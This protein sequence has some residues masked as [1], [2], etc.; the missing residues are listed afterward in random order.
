MSYSGSQESTGAWGRA[1]AHNDTMDYITNFSRRGI[2][3]IHGDADD[4]V[5]VREGRD[6]YEAVSAHTDDIYYHEQPG[7]GHWW[8]GDASAGADCVDWP[9]LFDLMTERRLDPYEL[10]F[11]FKSPTPSTSATH[12]YV[13]LHAASSPYEDMSL[14][15]SAS[16][17]NATLST[18]NVLSLSLQGDALLEQGITSISVNGETLSVEEGEMRVG[19]DSQKDSDSYGPFNQVLERPFVLV[20]PDDGHEAYRRYA[21]YLLSNWSVTGNG[22]GA[23]L[24]LSE[25]T[26]AMRAQYNVIYI[27]IPQSDVP[28]TVT[29]DIEWSTTAIRIGDR[30]ESGLAAVFVQPSESGGLF[31]VM[32]ATEGKE[33]VLFRYQPFASRFSAPDFFTFGKS[34]ASYSGFFDAQW[35]YQSSLVQ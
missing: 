33:A 26:D 18:T 24:G 32:T 17:S 14:T 6:M 7:A 8:D 10:E 31:G 23:A 2:Y 35:Q 34:G 19:S 22:H 30:S 28:E 3:I 27:G 15:A 16:G 11:D 9:P 5:P 4:N 21:A 29:A 12:S 25:L 13:T 1:A 20:Y